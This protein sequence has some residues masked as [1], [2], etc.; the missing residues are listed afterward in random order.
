MPRM[1]ILNSLEREAYDTPPE[2]NSVER[3]KYFDLS[4]N[5]TRIV[6]ILRNPTNRV[7]FVLACGYFRTA[8]RFFMGPLHQRDIDYVCAHL[9][10]PTTGIDANTYH[11]ATAMRHRRLILVH[12]G[13]KEFDSKARQ[14][15]K[16][17]IE[18]MVNSQLKPRLI[19]FRTVDIL[20]EQK[21]SPPSS[22]ALTK[23]ILEVL[24][25]RRE[26][27]ITVISQRLSRETRELL[28]QLLE[29]AINEKEKPINR[30]RLTLNSRA[31]QGGLGRS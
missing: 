4:Q 28:D 23:L 18:A 25:R 5:L 12:Y 27:L 29:K 19:F 6:E 1:N 26:Q 21:V 30:F 10:I 15:L 3:K 9:E 14:I 22:D 2:L 16:K 20:I 17:E 31:N 24:N 8:K 13:F 7:C 11:R